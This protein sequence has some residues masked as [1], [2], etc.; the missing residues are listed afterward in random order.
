MRALYNYIIHS[1]DLFYILHKLANVHDL[2]NQA[3]VEK[4]GAFQLFISLIIIVVVGVFTKVYFEGP[5]CP[6]SAKLTGTFVMMHTVKPPLGNGRWLLN[7]GL[8]TNFEYFFTM[9]GINFLVNME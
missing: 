8:C 9:D 2:Y 7:L 3:R 1:S 4:H 5:S 6:S